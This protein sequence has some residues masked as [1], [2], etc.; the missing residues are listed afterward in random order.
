[1]N[2]KNNRKGF[3]TVELVIV[4]A[5]IAILA[6]VLIPTFSN[7]INQ[8]NL[9]VDKQNVR[10]M[11]ICLATYSIT[12]GNPSD[13]YNVKEQL[14]KYGY[15]KD[16]NF[17][18]K[19]KGYTISW[20]TA[21]HDTPNDKTDDIS[22]ILLLDA[23][24]NVVFPEEY[25]GVIDTDSAKNPYK[26]FDL[27]LPAAKIEED[28]NAAPI[29]NVAG[30]MKDLS[31]KY[32]FTPARD[33]VNEKYE[34]WDADFY[35]SFEENGSKEFDYS[36]LNAVE[37]AGFYEGWTWNGVGDREGDGVEDWL[38]MPMSQLTAAIQ[39]S[40]EKEFALIDSFDGKP[41]IVSHLPYSI[42]SQMVFKCGVI[43]APSGDDVG[44]TINVELRLSN[45]ENEQLVIGI[46][47]YTFQ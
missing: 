43:D 18:A 13:F 12:D 23:G 46:Y 36:K 42:V 45:A 39:A 26:C 31:V 30:G 38:V 16:N 28:W 33:E 40:S 27:S 19:T 34:E 8:A 14:E 21:G 15:G 25:V 5:V 22:V 4:I 7:L 20:Y 32:T 3:T 9:S 17:V 2:M 11:N 29:K 24:K 41:E 47:S 37:F 35:I 6:T 10:N 44:I 1:M